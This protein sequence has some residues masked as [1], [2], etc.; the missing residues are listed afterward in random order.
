MASSSSS[1]TGLWVS[2]FLVG[3]LAL[4][5]GGYFF[6]DMFF[7]ARDSLD[8]AEV[9]TDVFPEEEG[10]PA[11]SETGSTTILLL[12]SD[13]RGGIGETLASAEGDRSDVMMV[14]RISGDREHVTAMS[15]MRDSW[16]EIPGRSENKI[17]AALAI[18]GVPLTVQTVENLLDTRIDHV[19][20]LDFEG[21][22][23]ITDVLG[24]VT[25]Q[26]ERAFT[27]V[28]LPEVTFPQGEVTL[29]GEEA[30]AFVRERMAFGSGDFQRVRNQQA[31]V[32]GLAQKVLDTK[33]IQDSGRIKALFEAV[34]P[35]FARDE[36]LTADLIIRIGGSL[37]NV[38][39][40]D[41]MFFTLPNLGTGT[42]GGQ[43]VVVVDF[44]QV[45]VIKGLLAEDRLQDYTPQT[46]Q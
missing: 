24:G 40:D 44:E 15:I 27:P 25:V 9:L 37:R 12:G 21:F 43:S 5:G 42:R 26:N 14:I 41:I 45:E 22:A 20:V 16:V 11:P 13:T 7:G 38:T 36:A 28:T 30:L 31:Y 18:G 3:L 2:V 19:A 35:Y 34:S 32:K 33:V 1:R 46:P 29:N 8:E 4:G 23:A 39:S 10:R 6:A 17:N